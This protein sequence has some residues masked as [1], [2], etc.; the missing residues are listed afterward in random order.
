MDK[1]GNA[2]RVVGSGI[3]LVVLLVVAVIV[4]TV[5]NDTVFKQSLS[6]TIGTYLEPLALLAGLT[7]AGSMAYKAMK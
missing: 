1:K 6:S 3:A 7:I 5:E 4:G 2:G